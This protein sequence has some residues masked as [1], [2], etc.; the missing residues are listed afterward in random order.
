MHGSSCL[1]EVRARRELVSVARPGY[2]GLALPRPVSLLRGG[3]ERHFRSGIATQPLSSHYGFPAPYPQPPEGAH[4]ALVPTA[5]TALSE[6]SDTFRDTHAG[7]SGVSIK[8]N[9]SDGPH[10][11]PGNSPGYGNRVICS[12]TSR[13]PQ[14]NRPAVPWFIVRS[15]I[16]TEARDGRFGTGQGPG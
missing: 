12:G 13:E 4:K 1:A 5:G 9:V 6:R 3:A 15:A 8:R 7:Q 16:L 14:G 10:R 2:G 11:Q